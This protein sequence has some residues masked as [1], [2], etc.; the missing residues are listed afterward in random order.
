MIVTIYIII[1][2]YFLLGAV[3]FYFINRKKDRSTARKS[4]IKYITYFIIIHALFF[5][6]IFNPLIFRIIALVIILVGMFELIKLFWNSG[7]RKQ[8]FFVVA[9]VLFVI[10]SAGFFRF[11]GLSKDLVL[12]TFLVLSIFD[13]FSQISGQLA[14]KRK[15]FPAISPGKTVEGLVGGVLIALASSL[16]LKSLVEFSISKTLL[17]AAGIVLFAFAGDLAA[18]VYKRKYNV[19]DFS[20]LLPGHGGF[21]DRFDSLITGGAF[22]GVIELLGFLN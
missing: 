5:G 9:F 22:V 15:L 11:T 4:W 8:S 3:A 16:L 7:Y 10:L 1:L 12:F 2:S 14:G 13:A 21:L 6:I 17:I 20:Q 19:K 18:S